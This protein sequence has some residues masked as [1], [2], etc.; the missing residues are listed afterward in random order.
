MKYLIDT[1]WVI[2]FLKGLPDA[3][4][5]L[6]AL[7][8]EGAA[9]SLITVGEIYDGVYGSTDPR[10]SEAGFLLFLEEVA[11]LPLDQPI[12]KRFAQIRRELRSKGQRLADLDLLIAA[13]ALHYGLTL[14]TRNVAHFQ[15]IG[16]L[17]IYKAGQNPSS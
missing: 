7:A 10:A 17:N 5:L 14:A 9:I 13:T 11:V 2:D 4:L 15:R 12:V 6:R 3:T 1:D 16:G 8:Y